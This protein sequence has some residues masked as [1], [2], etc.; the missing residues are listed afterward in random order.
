MAS[1]LFQSFARLESVNPDRHVETSRQQLAV[2]F[3]EL[4]TSD[5]LRMSFLELPEYGN[6]III[7]ETILTGWLLFVK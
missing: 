4:D 2:V 7:T 6:F 3:A 1:H 5:A